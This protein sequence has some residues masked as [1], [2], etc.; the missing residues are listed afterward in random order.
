[1]EKITLR[2][3]LLSKRTILSDKLFLIRVPQCEVYFDVGLIFHSFAVTSL[4]DF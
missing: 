3:L 4:F 1:M 2:H